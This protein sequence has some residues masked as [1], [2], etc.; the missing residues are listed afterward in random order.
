MQRTVDFHD[1]EE[2]AHMQIVQSVVN[3]LGVTGKLLQFLWQRKWWWL[4][5]MMLMLLLLAGAIIFA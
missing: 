2:L 4:A 1:V 3:H 5:P